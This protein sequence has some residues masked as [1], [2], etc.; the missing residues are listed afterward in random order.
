MSRFI[1]GSVFGAAKGLRYPSA[2]DEVASGQDRVPPD[3]PGAG[4]AHDG[5]DLFPHV[6]PVAMDGA[7][8]AGGLFRPEGTFVETLYG[9]GEKPLAI[10][11]DFPFCSVAV[12]AEDPDHGREG[13]ALPLDSGVCFCH[14]DNIHDQS[15]S[16]LSYI[17]IAFFLVTSG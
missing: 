12:P 17:D 16:R 4:M 15:L 1:C 2:I 13:F 3:H 8:G 14:K 9:V 10:A 7:V 5:T 11:A 6:G